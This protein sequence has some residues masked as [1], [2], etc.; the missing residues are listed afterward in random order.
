MDIEEFVKK[1]ICKN[2]SGVQ[3][4]LLKHPPKIMKRGR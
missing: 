3:I 2:L 4:E 1:F